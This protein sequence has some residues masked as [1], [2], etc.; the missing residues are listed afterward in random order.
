ML[1][2]PLYTNFMLK[3]N[4]EL[5]L[6]ERR[7]KHKLRAR[8]KQ[9]KLRQYWGRRVQFAIHCKDPLKEEFARE[10]LRLC[11]EQLHQESES[12]ADILVHNNHHAFEKAQSLVEDIYR[13]LQQHDPDAGERVDPSF[14]LLNH[15]RKGTQLPHM[16]QDSCALWSYTRS[17]FCERAFLVS[18]S[19]RCLTRKRRRGDESLRKRLETVQT[20][21]CIGCGPGNDAV[22]LVA[23]VESAL[24]PSFSFLLL[25]DYAIEA[26]QV[27]HRP[28]SSLLVP[29]H[30]A[31]FE[32][33][34]C[35]VKESFQSATNQ[36]LRQRIEGIDMFLISYLLTE[37]HGQWESFL[38][39][40]IHCAKTGTLF[41]FAEPRPWQLQLLLGMSRGL[42]DVVWLDTSMDDPAMQA[43]GSRVG[44]AVFLAM[45][46]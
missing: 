18:R 14:A 15:M 7:D 9:V 17:K 8:Q 13:K 4:R 3:P 37:T 11:D 27:V 12:V 33:C 45:K 44:P 36:L 2:L 19:L 31:Q 5:T 28:L 42:L 1:L 10:Q 30:V 35:N 24:L 22:G 34:F 32:T 41:Y 46:R 39:P 43:L 29:R 23:F 38:V 20:A 16:F 21:C 40:L 26:W 6:Q 25:C